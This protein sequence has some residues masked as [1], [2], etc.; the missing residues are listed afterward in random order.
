MSVTWHGLRD[1]FLMAWG[2]V[3]GARARLR[4]LGDRPGASAAGAHRAPARRPP[5]GIHR[6]GHRPGRGFVLLL[7][8]GRGDCQVALSEGREYGQ[9][10]LAFQIASTNLVWKLGLV[11]WVL[12]GWQFTLGEY[13]GGV[14]VIALMALSL[15]V[16]VRGSLE[17]QARAKAQAADAGHHHHHAAERGTGL[18]V[19]HSFRHDWK[20]LWKEIA[21]GFL[22]AGFVAQLGNGFFQA[23]SCA[24]RPRRCPQSRTYSSGR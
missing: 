23:L 15:R 17:E 1:A 12:I 19:A 13:V 5:R 3:V 14:V 9:R 16:L 8:R 22:L 4:D 11:L 2:A 20:M 21:I 24:T 10:A 7:I 18:Q 6:L